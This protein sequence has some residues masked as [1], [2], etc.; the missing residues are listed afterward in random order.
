MSANVLAI[1]I[2]G[3]NIVYGIVSPD[4][5]VLE[6]DVLRLE[7]GE[8]SE[9]V[10]QVKFLIKSYKPKVEAVGIGFPGIVNPDSGEIIFDERSQ[11]YEVDWDEDIPIAIDNDANLAALAEAWVGETQDVSN[12]IFI[13]LGESIDSGIFLEGHLYRGSHYSSG[14]ISEVITSNKSLD[15]ISGHNFPGEFSESDKST[16]SFVC[17]Q[18][19]H[20]YWW[21]QGN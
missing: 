7:N 3:M 21:K 2:D 20:G 16:L 1:D 13:V 4:G 5:K 18:L 10:R 12:F 11:K 8:A 6:E 17:E 19:P 14:E 9:V 15:C